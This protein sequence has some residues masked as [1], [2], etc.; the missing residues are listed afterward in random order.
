MKILIK[1]SAFFCNS[2]SLRNAIYGADGS[3]EMT[4]YA[5]RAEEDGLSC[6]SIKAESLMSC[7]L[8]GAVASAAADTLV[9]V[10]YRICNGVTVKAAGIGHILVCKADYLRHTAVACGSEPA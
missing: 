9:F 4:A 5:L 7:V 1:K 8:A 6:F 10:E 2:F 3:A